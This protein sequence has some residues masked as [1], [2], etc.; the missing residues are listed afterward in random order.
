MHWGIEDFKGLRS[1]RLQLDP[2]GLT[3]LTGVNSSGKSSVLQSI[4]M[5]TQSLYH[6]GGVVLNGPLVR[7]GEAKDLVR[8]G[9]ESDGVRVNI[10]VPGLTDDDEED[11]DQ[12][13][14][15]SAELVPSSDNTTLHASRLELTYVGQPE[16]GSALLT[17]NRSRS[18][19]LQAAASLTGR[20]SYNFL[21]LQVTFEPDR[22]AL[23][24]YVRMDGFD[25]VE[26]VQFAERSVIESKFRKY[27]EPVL[28]QI[29]QRENLRPD[30]TTQ[31]DSDI[32]LPLVIREF[33]VLLRQALD[34][35]GKRRNSR[36][37]NLAN[38]Q[39]RNPYR[40]ADE[41]KKLDKV[42]RERAIEAAV[43]VRNSRLYIRIPVSSGYP[44]TYLG[45]W[46]PEGVLEFRLRRELESTIN[47]L[48]A[49]S[50]GLNSV[51]RSVQYLGP[52]RDE[53]RVVWDQW[54]ELARGL[55]VGTRG[56]F[57]AVRLSQTANRAVEFVT[58][59]KVAKTATL[60]SAVNDWLGY[61]K[62]GEKVMAKSHGKLGVGMELEVA[63]SRRDLTAVGVGVSQ[64]LPLVVAFLA[65]ES[66][67]I[68]IVEQPELH[69]HP[70]VQARLADFLVTARPD[71]TSI[72]ETH[73][74]AFVTRLRRRVADGTISKEKVG[75]SFVEVGSGG[76][77]M[78]ALTV[79]EFGDLSEWPSGFISGDDE[80][81]KAILVANIAKIQRADD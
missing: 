16:C 12:P 58:P 53:P 34:T 1:G 78:R 27:I 40:F 67:S 24:T 80:D 9:A 47:A 48:R 18:A 8:T 25:P 23:R 21:R 3:V 15:L 79:S 62:I 33:Q 39:Y 65:V 61:L 51:A 59:E 77:T 20:S 41:W 4:L 49:V 56:E 28:E 46:S 35:P 45:A 10:E 38:V 50:E 66:G 7:L 2:G 29:Y 22:K 76:S 72:V 57:S 71:V 11:H 32:P 81:T 75:I 52:L 17:R 63:G 55:P 37:R 68:F 44:S 6:S 60:G 13:V 30:T 42:T 31:A 70:A 5:M 43:K 19:D 73:S 64:A 54:N 14:Q 74:E 26:V 69:L 36:F